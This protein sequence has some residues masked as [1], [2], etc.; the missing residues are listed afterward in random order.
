MESCRGIGTAGINNNRSSVV[1]GLR[2]RQ[3]EITDGEVI[4]GRIVG[5]H[6]CIE[7]SPNDSEMRG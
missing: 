4:V 7:G 2:N 5:K 3:I 1:K 6:G